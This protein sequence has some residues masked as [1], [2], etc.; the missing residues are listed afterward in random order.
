MSNIEVIELS[1]P[2]NIQI[3]KGE[4]VMH[5]IGEHQ[6]WTILGHETNGQMLFIDDHHQSS[7]TDE[8]IYHESFVHS[9][10]CGIQNPKRILILGGSEGCMA[11]EVLRWP[12]VESIVQVDWDAQLCGWFRMHGDTWH[13]GAYNDP[14]LCVVHQDALEWL[15]NYVDSFDA[16]FVDLFDPT[17]IDVPFFKEVLR[18]CRLKLACKGGLAVNVGPVPKVA[19][20]ILKELVGLIQNEY[21]VARFQ[22]LAA[23]VHV[24]SFLGEWCF[25]VAAPKSW[26]AVIHDCVLP[27]GLQYFNKERLL[28]MV[29]WSTDTP[30]L[31][32]NFWK[33]EPAVN[34]A[35][36]LAARQLK[37]EDYTDIL[38]HYGC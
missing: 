9:L 23:H 36:Q 29:S 34:P 35:G 17:D 30:E 3:Y 33:Y 28:D 14:R 31:L 24:P 25:L 12:T 38:E 18:L 13:K 2:K 19:T 37:K 5:H 7:Q 32:R 8:H 20:E 4:H 15:Q 21:S 6:N 27:D 16:V 11:R 10:L 26:A 1:D 22:L